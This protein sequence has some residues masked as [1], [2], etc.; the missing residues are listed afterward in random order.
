MHNKQG[1]VEI[2]IF[3][4]GPKADAVLSHFPQRF[5][6]DGTDLVF[7]APPLQG[8]LVDE[9]LHWFHMALKEQR[10]FILKLQA[11]GVQIAIR[12]SIKGRCL[13][14][15]PEALLLAHQLHLSIEMRFV[16]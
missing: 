5:V 4:P 8:H 14:M 6:S 13:N 2:R 12:I 10:K 16:P 11:D 7:R 15:K 9:Q 1:D 3:S